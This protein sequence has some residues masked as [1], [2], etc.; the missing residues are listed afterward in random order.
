[1]AIEKDIEEIQEALKEMRKEQERT[2]IKAMVAAARGKISTIDAVLLGS[3][4][5]LSSDLKSRAAS[6]VSGAVEPALEGLA[7]DRALE[8][9]SALPEPRFSNPVIG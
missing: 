7:A 6:K 3:L 9:A 2:V 8:Q 1:M 5:G 4:E